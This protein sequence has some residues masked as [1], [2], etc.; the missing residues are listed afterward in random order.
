MKKAVFIDKD[1]TLIKNVSYNIDADL[2]LLEQ[3]AGKALLQLHTNNY[4]LIVISNQS[5]IADGFF[6]EMDLEEINTEIQLQLSLYNVHID[7]F[8]Y[9]PHLP[10]GI[11]PEYAVDCDC[12]KPKPGLILKAANDF[13]IDLKNS[14][15][16]GDILNDIEAGN[17]AGCT[18]I[19]IDNGNETEWLL[20]EQRNP[21]YKVRNLMEAADI[22][23]T[24]GKKTEAEIY[25]HRLA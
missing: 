22:I 11:I 13:N 7:A 5:G 19:L 12:R 1:G 9:C 8:Y 23:I 16:I 15:M 2:V 14:W 10:N 21:A 18:S 3:Y 17:S 25:E 24:K 4:S 6:K 20:N